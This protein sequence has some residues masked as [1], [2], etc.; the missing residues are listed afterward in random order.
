MTR[1]TVWQ[2]GG[3]T[4][5]PSFGLKCAND[6]VH[7]AR[8]ERALLELL[9]QAKGTLVSKDQLISG[10]WGD[11]AV[12]DE[13][14]SRCVYTLRRALSRPDG[15]DVVKTVYGG[16]LRICVPV[17]MGPDEAEDDP[18]IP[19]ATSSPAV[20][21]RWRM[22]WEQAGGRSR[23]SLE[24]ALVTF[25]RA[26][27][28]DPASLAIPLTIVAL[29]ISQVNR[30]YIAS[31]DAADAAG[32]II[33]SILEKAPGY[34]PAIACRAYF[35]A[36]VDRQMS[37]ALAE[38]DWAVQAMAQNHHAGYCRAWVLSGMG[39]LDEAVR[40]IE[41]WIHSVSP[42][43]GY[44]A[45]YTWMLYCAGRFDDALNYAQRALD[46]R[47][48]ND[49]VYTTISAIHALR[50]NAE[51]AI[52]AAAKAME[53]A[54]G[55]SIA[56]DHL[57]YAYAVAGR[58]DDARNLLLKTNERNDPLSPF[59]TKAPAWLALGHPEKAL[60]ALRDS[61]NRREP[62]FFFAQY[63]PRFAALGPLPPIR[64]AGQA[65]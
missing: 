50:G 23:G 45:A 33:A 9:L 20:I 49:L 30:G 44:T 19:P 24:R 35:R 13:S 4:Y 61:D 51:G 3:F 62:L 1:S 41:R 26:W 29:Q 25:Q 46:E 15:Q 48:E 21:R 31:R 5:D 54:G 64:D 43:R 37:A 60:E 38:L 39:R 56:E 14:L 28:E 40:E 36:V 65:G 18:L 22:G 7:L 10:I 12:S 59:I 57:A 8:K 6:S 32:K 55:E 16:G 11:G 53:F 2:F 58:S 27:E 47:P 17:L 42:E 34:P 63:D 52:E